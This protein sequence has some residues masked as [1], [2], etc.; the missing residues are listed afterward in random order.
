VG[1]AQ[2]LGEAKIGNEESKWANQKRNET[3]PKE[4]DAESTVQPDTNDVLSPD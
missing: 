3:K 1:L 2:G 4:K